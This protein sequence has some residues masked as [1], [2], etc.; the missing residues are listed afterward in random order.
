MEIT[1]NSL[2]N[3]LELIEIKGDTY[4]KDAMLNISKN[5]IEV[6]AA[7]DGSS[8]IV[9]GTIKGVFEDIGNIGIDSFLLLINSINEFSS[10][11]IFFTKKDNKLLLKSPDNKLK[12]SLVLK[13]PD[14]IINKFTNEQF[15][16]ILKKASGNEFTLSKET[17]TK[18]ASY[19]KTL[20]TNVL[21]LKGSKKELT[22]EIDNKTGNSTTAS[23][24][25]I[26]VFD[27]EHPLKE[28]FSIKLSNM[29]LDIFSSIGKEGE[30]S[31]RNNAPLAIKSSGED[32]SITYICNTLKITKED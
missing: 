15:N 27:L 1:K 4:F 12:I 10:E 11:K 26:A 32:Y 14:Y 31:T 2:K 3:F 21:Y 17:V 6:T 19:C 16:S 22:L 7:N 29:F 24:S 25:I 23:S 13:N 28:D 30:V 8:M 20:N 5:S 9:S 18:I